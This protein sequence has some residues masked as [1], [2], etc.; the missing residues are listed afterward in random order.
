MRLLVVI[1]TLV[2]AA[3]GAAAWF[4]AEHIGLSPEYGATLAVSMTANLS[5]LGALVLIWRAQKGRAEDRQRLERLERHNIAASRALKAM[6]TQTKTL[7]LPLDERIARLERAAEVAARQEATPQ[8]QPAPKP[9]SLADEIAAVTA[10][11]NRTVEA[12]AAE[13]AATDEAQ[14]D[15]LAAAVEGL[16]ARYTKKGKPRRLAAPTAVNDDPRPRARMDAAKAQLEDASATAER[17][18]TQLLKQTLQGKGLEVKLAPV[19]RIANRRVLWQEATSQ[20]GGTGG[21]LLT[22]ADY[23]PL[24]GAAGMMPEHDTHLVN[25][26]VDTLGRMPGN[27]R[28]FFNL[29]PTSLTTP[30]PIDALTRAVDA[31]PRISQRLVVEFSQDAIRTMGAEEIRGLGT[32]SRLGFDLS[33]DGVEDLRLDWRAMARQGFRFVKVPAHV[34]CGDHAGADVHP[35][36]LGAL[37]DRYGLS[38]IA[39]NVDGEGTLLQLADHDLHFAQG[40]LFSA[41]LA[42]DPRFAHE[43][44]ASRAA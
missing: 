12:R 6:P 28:L 25:A 16:V 8:P 32:L 31:D 35:A 23:L 22:P 26:V 36:D 10:A 29:H 13:A 39:E 9:E 11:M 44:A 7:F 18:A 17:L 30:G 3:G 4:A 33:M 21:G 27:M 5:A 43:V 42:N 1:C 40:R 34:L 38:L 24:A 15:D 41:A 14:G 2:S 37:V 20:L 19:C